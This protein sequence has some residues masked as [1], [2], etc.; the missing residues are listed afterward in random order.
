M[1]TNKID[2]LQSVVSNLQEELTKQKLIMDSLSQENI[3]TKQRLGRLQPLTEL[4]DLFE[5]PEKFQTFLEDL[6]M[7]I[8]ADHCYIKDPIRQFH[9]EVPDLVRDKIVEIVKIEGLSNIKALEKVVNEAL[10]DSE[11]KLKRK[12]RT[13][14]K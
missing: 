9:M 3:K 12:T 4:A 7:G 5:T 10:I 11:K 8:K 2:S 14:S 13:Y 1:D 6:K